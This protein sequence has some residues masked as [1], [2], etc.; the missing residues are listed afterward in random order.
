MRLPPQ[1]NE[2]FIAAS[3]ASFDS[4]KNNGGVAAYDMRTLDKALWQYSNEN[5]SS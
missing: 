4:G 1:E 3:G 2:S 5:Q